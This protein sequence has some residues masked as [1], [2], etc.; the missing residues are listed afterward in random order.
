M[1]RHRSTLLVGGMRDANAL[2]NDLANL[3]GASSSRP[4]VP[5]AAVGPVGWLLTTNERNVRR[6]K[7]R[8]YATN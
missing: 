1:R 4:I 2:I 7:R 6:T 8:F 5:S 3:K